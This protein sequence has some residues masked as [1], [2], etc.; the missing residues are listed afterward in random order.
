MSL[1]SGV[2]VTAANVTPSAVA[3]T[4]ETQTAVVTVVAVAVVVSLLWCKICRIRLLLFCRV[5]FIL[6]GY[7]NV[8][9]VTV[10]LPVLYMPTSAA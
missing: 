3:M 8:A 7:Y 6:C 10:M 9:C 4:A 5:A 2:A 1:V